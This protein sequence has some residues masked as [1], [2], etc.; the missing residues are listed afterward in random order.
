M[1]ACASPVKLE[2]GG[3]ADRARKIKNK[4][5]VNITQQVVEL[6]NLRE[7]AQL[8]KAQ[9]LKLTDGFGLMPEL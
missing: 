9:I 4:P 2:Y 6:N 1:I 3:D 5:I 8:L 7:Q